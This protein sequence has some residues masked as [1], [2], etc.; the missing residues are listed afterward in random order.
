LI[1]C[2]R[3]SEFAKYAQILKNSMASNE[4]AG[5]R[6]F[7]MTDQTAVEGTVELGGWRW[8]WKENRLMSVLLSYDIS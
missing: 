7:L 2:D 1:E 6:M 4:T 5:E 8:W 3:A